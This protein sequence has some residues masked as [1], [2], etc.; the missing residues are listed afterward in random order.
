[1][2]KAIPSDRC[3]SPF[4]VIPRSEGSLTVLT[5]PSFR[6]TLPSWFATAF[7]AV[8]RFAPFVK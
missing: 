4:P 8:A 6:P 1:M 7:T 2:E 5:T 3:L